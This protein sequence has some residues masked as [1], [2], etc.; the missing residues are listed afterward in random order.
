MLTRLKRIFEDAVDAA[1]GADGAEDEAHAVQRAAA[2]LLVEMTRADSEVT[3]AEREHV[4][5]ALE[6]V[7]RL[8]R[9]EA[10]A[11]L[12]A[13]T[14][15]AHAATSLYEFT[16]LLNQR[17]EHQQKVQLVEQLWR[18]AYADG[19]LEKHEAHL[20]RKVADLLHLRHR[21]YI[22]GKLRAGG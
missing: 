2:A 13:A 10:A 6:T 7:F 22:G 3:D 16:S 9:E 12:E 15:D 8:S 14:E 17:F 1:A 4:A 11:L 21:E 5:S 18:V 19:E 20:V